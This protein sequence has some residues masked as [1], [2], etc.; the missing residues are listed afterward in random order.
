MTTQ[1]TSPTIQN[2]KPQLIDGVLKDKRYPDGGGLY[3]LATAK[4]GK[5]WRYNYSM[6]GKKYVYSLGEYPALSLKDARMIHGELKTHI[7]KGINP[8]EKKQ[9]EKQEVKRTANNS[10]K[11]VAEAYLSMQDGKLALSTL[12]KH[13][14]ALERDFYPIIENMAID[15]IE[16]RDLIVVATAIQ[17]R[18]GDGN[19]TS[20]FKPM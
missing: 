9:K 18:G 20:S 3:L 19:C 7:A 1:L 13:K 6:Q 16:R 12:L 8:V 4:G 10:F 15:K 5:L 11:E 2:A 17:N 14:R